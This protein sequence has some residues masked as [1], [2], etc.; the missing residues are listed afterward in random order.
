[1]TTPP[2]VLAL[3]RLAFLDDL[4]VSGHQTVGHQVDASAGE[5]M[6]GELLPAGVSKALER[7]GATEAAGDQTTLLELGSGT[8]K[9][10]LQAFLE[11]PGLRRIVGVELSQARHAAAVVA[12]SRLAEQRPSFSLAHDAQE[13]R[14]ILRDADGRVL[15]LW[16]DDLTAMPAPLVQV[17]SYLLLQVVLPE[18]VQEAAQRVLLHAPDGCKALLLKDLT[19]AWALEQPCPWHPIGASADCFATSWAPVHGHRLH[20]YEADRGRP[21]SITLGSALAALQD[22]AEEGHAL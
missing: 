1:M 7:M 4:G 17:A 5:L 10:A 2:D 21:A 22:D 18:R 15:E 20:L 8:G 14:S 19:R 12:V 16:C 13:G 3:L 9:V 11:C 6:Y